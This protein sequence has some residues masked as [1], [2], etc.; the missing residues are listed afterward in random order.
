[1]GAERQQNVVDV[2]RQT[3]RPVPPCGDRSGWFWYITSIRYDVKH[4]V[5]HKTENT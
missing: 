2:W 5:I 3:S 1:M 4:D